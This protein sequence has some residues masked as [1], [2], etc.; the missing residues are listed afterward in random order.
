MIRFCTVISAS[1]V[2]AG[3]ALIR[4]LQRHAKEF[5]LHVLATDNEVS[6]SLAAIPQLERSVSFLE[7]SQIISSDDN[8]KGLSEELSERAFSKHLR[9]WLV[10]HL[11]RQIPPGELL[12][13]ISPTVFFY[14][15][16]GTITQDIG[17]ASIVLI[18]SADTNALYDRSWASFRNDPVGLACSHSWVKRSLMRDNLF[19]NEHNRSTYLESSFPHIQQLHLVVR[20][21]IYTPL[22][23]SLLNKHIGAGPTINGESVIAFNFHG[24]RKLADGIYDPGPV[25]RHASPDSPLKQLICGPYLI[26]LPLSSHGNYPPEFVP[27]NTPTDPRA[28]SVLQSLIDQAVADHDACDNLKTALSQEIGRAHV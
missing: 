24:L 9:P 17:E 4:S 16:P 20:S 6:T 15:H 8:L 23:L 7:L 5:H 18:R 2:V 28:N 26:E 10:Q 19:S 3:H 14:S 22:D 1:D 21:G 27:L 25:L 11:L 13:L 12:T